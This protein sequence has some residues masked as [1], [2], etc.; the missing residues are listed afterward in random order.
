MNQLIAVYGTLRKG[1]SNHHV[2]KDSPF[3]KTTRLKGFVMYGANSF[4]AVIRGTKKDE[5]TVEIYR[6]TDPAILKELDL[7]EGF[8]R[9][10]PMDQNSLYTIQ[11]IYLEGESE[12]IE[13]YT[14]DHH[15]AMVHQIGPQIKSGDWLKR[16]K[17]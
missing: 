12:P 6:V 10:N 4:P 2:L 13:M 7:L 8:D 3:I 11:E 17:N 16:N 1:E 5:I 15:P 14:F 9:A